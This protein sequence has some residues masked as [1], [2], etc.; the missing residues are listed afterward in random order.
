M[1][2]RAN[3][4]KYVNKKEGPRHNKSSTFMKSWTL[5]WWPEKEA[6]QKSDPATLID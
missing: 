3:Q 4:E 1:S 5:P 2:A 6:N